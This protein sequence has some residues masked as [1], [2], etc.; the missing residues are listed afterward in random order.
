MEALMNQTGPRAPPPPP[1]TKQP[2]PTKQ[3]LPVT[4]DHVSK[5]EKSKDNQDQ[6]KIVAADACICCLTVIDVLIAFFSFQP[7]ASTRGLFPLYIG[8]AK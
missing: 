6:A 5:V 1:P 8:G 3:Q 7:K 4:T 2:K